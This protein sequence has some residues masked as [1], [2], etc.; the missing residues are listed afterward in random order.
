MGKGSKLEHSQHKSM[1]NE[2]FIKW[3]KKDYKRQL[4]EWD[5]WDGTLEHGIAIN[6][7]QCDRIQAAN[8]RYQTTYMHAFN[9]SQK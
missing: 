4:H 6:D 1:D 5:G 2:Q 8:D 9:I 7:K 3:W